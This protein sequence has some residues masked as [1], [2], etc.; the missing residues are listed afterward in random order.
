MSVQERTLRE[1][2]ESRD[3]PAFH[4]MAASDV[5]EHLGTTASGLDDAA[6][7]E[8]LRQYG[9]NALPQAQRRGLIARFF[10]QLNNLLIFVLIGAAAITVGLGHLIDAAVIMV[11]VVINGVVGVVQEGRAENAL[12][13]IRD[14]L[15]PRANVM[16]N[17]HRTSIDSADVVPGDIVLLEPGDRV[18]ADLRLLKAR[19]LRVDEALLTGESLAVD[20]TS[21]P[22]EDEASLGDRRSMAFSGTL[23]AAGQ[24]IGVVVATGSKTE[25][26]RISTML[27][28]IG[29]LTTPL[30]RQMD[31]FAKYLTVVI[32]VVSA[33]VF[34]FG[35][36]VRDY[37]LSEMF[38]AAIGIAVAAIPEGLPAVLTITLAIGVQRMAS[39]HAIVRHLPAIETLGAVSVICSDKTGTLTRNEMTVRHVQVGGDL[40]EVEGVGYAP[41]GGFSRD[42]V[43]LDIGETAVLARLI[44]TGLL[45]N[46]AA[47][48]QLGDDWI[49]EGDPM[50]GALVA[51]ALKAGVERS[52]LNK[53]LPRTDEIPFD[54]DHRFMATLHH[55]HQGDA[56]ICVKG[57]PERVIAM[58]ASEA[59]EEGDVD[60]AADVWLARVDDLASRGERVLA[61]AR[62]PVVAHRQ[63]LTFDDMQD[64]FVL[65]GLVSLIDPPREE[66]IAAVRDC[67]AA[68]IRV[69]MITG[70]HIAT[71]R[72]IAAQLNLTHP[73]AA[74]TGAELDLLDD[75]TLRAKVRE[76]DVFARTSPEHKLRLVDALQAEG[77]VIVMTGD[78]VNDAPALKRADVG[79]AMGR[80]GTEAA[81]EASRM[82][83]TDDN[84]SSIATAVREGRTVYDNLR[85][86]I[87]WTLPTNG[88]QA[89]AIIAAIL[90]GVTLPIT[91]VQILWVNMVTAVALGL[92][93]AFEPSEPGVMKRAPR[94]PDEPLLTGF[95]AWRVGF[96]SVLFT[97]SAF[98]VFAWSGMRYD[99]LEISR[100]FVVNM[101]VVLQIFYLFSV[102]Y[103]HMT[104][105]TWRGALGT[106]AVLIGVGLV[107]VVQFLFTYAPFM[108][109]LFDS[110][111][112]SFTDGLVIMG[113]GV[114]FFLVL[115][116]EKLLRRLIWGSEW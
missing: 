11:V 104:S 6:V 59:G 48:N 63:D 15:M 101:L 39:R 17:A 91:P 22:V 108:H 31:R 97:I 21:E 1:G 73:D 86:T 35:G 54:A 115:E 27:S 29:T 12:D 56:F 32:L 82:V 79:V 99:S 84:F 25:L 18:P 44:E 53:R 67:Q 23:V 13:A 2:Q 78:G 34:L 96:V 47:L 14:M 58:C 107:T 80:K 87:A 69:K 95:L 114:A 109:T 46:D 64:G 116:L 70:D 10:A 28:G 8:R 113:V 111:S 24:G 110:R 43:D 30:L 72:A 7:A 37:G 42:G 40:V 71:A 92:T 68:G 49:V 65:L 75:E 106:P 9:P 26:G 38:M 85:K 77:D 57:A 74:M 83:L 61:L 94:R 100:T 41:R 33:A 20:K 16:R 88:G 93:L 60:L 36:L 102:R 52:T 112:L 90:L 51:L 3:A 5:L 66:A 62:K 98:G 50:E 45:C 55:S 89:L 103:Q 105:L 76:A 19:G 4:T 81:K